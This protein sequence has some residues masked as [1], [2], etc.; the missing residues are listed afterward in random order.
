MNRLKELRKISGL[1]L[2]NMANRFNISP[3]AYRKY[4][5]EEREPNYTLLIQFA[6][7]FN[8]SVDYLLGRTDKRFTSDKSFTSEQIRLL[9][10]FDALIPPMQEYILEMVEK[11]IK[12]PQNVS[13]RA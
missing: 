11:L 2:Q 7:Y 10:A 5:N 3:E 8:V 9:N 4:E 6:D 1:T 12:Q 13:K